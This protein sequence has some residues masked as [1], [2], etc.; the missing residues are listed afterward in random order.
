[1][2][3]WAY[4][5]TYY[6]YSH[7]NKSFE[8]V[9][10]YGLQH[11]EGSCKMCSHYNLLKYRIAFKVTFY[12]MQGEWEGTYSSVCGRAGHALNESRCTVLQIKTN[13]PGGGK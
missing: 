3:K 6:I 4:I 12:L 9:H 8:M 10:A 7:C 13:S 11:N 5:Y 2:P 1:M